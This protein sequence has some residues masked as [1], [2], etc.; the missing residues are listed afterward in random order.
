M[1][2]DIF[3]LLFLA[4][5]VLAVLFTIV[6]KPSVIRPRNWRVTQEAFN[7]ER[8]VTRNNLH[9]EGDELSRTDEWWN[10]SFAH[11]ISASCI[12]HVADDEDFSN[13]RLSCGDEC[14]DPLY[15]HLPC[16]IYYDSSSDDDI[17]DNSWDNAFD[18]DWR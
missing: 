4:I 1:G 14:T 5:V 15:S 8:A 9:L 11:R 18:D 10:N 2:F 13:S 7:Q 17:F 12:G 16:N 6:F 3:V